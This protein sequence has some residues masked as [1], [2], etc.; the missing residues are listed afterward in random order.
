ML[1]TSWKVVPRAVC[2]IVFFLRLVT[3][4]LLW[5]F[6][7]PRLPYSTIWKLKM[8]WPQF[9]LRKTMTH[10]GFRASMLIDGLAIVFLDALSVGDLFGA[11]G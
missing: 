10:R 11:R 4:E 6:R 5:E 8:N 7:L 1:A 3:C 2:L 9:F